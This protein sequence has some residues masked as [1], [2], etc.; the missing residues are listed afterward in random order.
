MKVAADA[1]TRKLEQILTIDPSIANDLRDIG[2]HAPAQP[3]GQERDAWYKRVNRITRLRHD[4]CICDCFIATVRYMGGGEAVP[5][6][7]WTAERKHSFAMAEV[8]S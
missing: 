4:S 5:W 8:R 3:I 2:S 6:W 7:T 1:M